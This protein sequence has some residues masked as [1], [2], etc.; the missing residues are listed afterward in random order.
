MPNRSPSPSRFSEHETEEYYDAEDA[1][2]RSFWDAEGSLH[3][4]VFDAP[5]EPGSGPPSPA[6]NVRDG[7]LTAWSRLN[8][9]MLE[10][11]GIDESARVLDCVK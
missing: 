10:N 8:A 3:W 2:Y 1:L 5:A 7:F 6:S 9:I 4:G 11:S